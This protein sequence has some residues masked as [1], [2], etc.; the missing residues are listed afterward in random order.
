MEQIIEVLN[1]N[2]NKYYENINHRKEE[3]DEVL[4]TYEQEKINDKKINYEK[5][6][7]VDNNAK[8]GKKK[9]LFRK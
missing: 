6:Y 2:K 5:Y 8:K 9:R 4:D 1:N 7:Y 3:L